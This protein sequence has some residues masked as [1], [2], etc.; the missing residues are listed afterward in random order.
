MNDGL[1]TAEQ[2]AEPMGLSSSHLFRFLRGLCTIGICE[3]LPDKRFV[4]TSLGRTLL[5]GSSSDLRDKVMI[6][7]EQYWQ[8]WANLVHSLK[9]GD[10]AFDRVFGMT[11]WDWRRLRH[12]SAVRFDAF[13]AQA[14]FAQAASIL[15]VL[16][17]SQAKT[18]ADIGGGCGGLIAALVQARAHIAGVL[19][20]Q[21][22]TI[23]SA[24]SFLQSLGVAE[25]VDLV[26]GD[27]MVEIP[28]RADLYLLKSV[29]HDWGDAECRA[30]LTQCRRAMPD[31]AKLLVI[32]RPLPE[33]ALDDPAA[34][35]IDMR[36]MVITGGRERSLE[37]Y[38]SLLSGSGLKPTDV[39]ATRAGL[40][41]I[42]AV[43]A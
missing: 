13:L 8:P 9:T 23:E 2:L 31:K 35:M 4:L 29:L 7:V 12:E 1:W 43:P 14:T 38:R 10:P 20:D 5:S 16:D 19:F 24:K 28:V 34:I 30:I 21:P 6:V 26:S 33:R 42:E 37:Q 3:E 11:V 22:Q 41:L 25:R 27:F 18:V 17:T 15:E 39:T 40:F 36:M 32:E